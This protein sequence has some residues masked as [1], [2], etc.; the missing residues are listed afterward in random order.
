MIGKERFEKSSYQVHR[1]FEQRYVMGGA[2]ESLAKTWHQSGTVDSWRHQR[3]YQCVDPLL[4]TSPGAK[5]L[6]VGDGRCGTDAAYLR[7]HG[8][9]VVASS[10]SDALLKEAKGLGLIDEYSAENAE[11]LSFDD[12][13]FDYVFCKESFHHFPRPYLALYEM[14]RVARQGVILIEPSEMSVKYRLSFVV[15]R[16]AKRFMI[17]CGLSRWLRTPGDLSLFQG[18]ENYWEEVGNYIYTLSER[19]IVK[20]ALGLNY[21][22]VAFKGI[23]D[24]YVKGVEYEP[25]R[26]DSALFGKVKRSIMKADI[27]ALILNRPYHN[28]VACIFK[29]Q[30]VQATRDA[31]AKQGYKVVD[32]PRNPHIGTSH[33]MP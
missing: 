19:E 8:A 21:P 23:N 15:K 22:V 5:W 27:L 11:A 28:L 14:L 32:L 26:A 33:E 29:Q 12:S 25:C 13:S 6:T 4:V 2:E 1:D 24:C 17:A 16:M 20:T 30:P 7:R 31:L 10:I 18:P 9:R 3:M